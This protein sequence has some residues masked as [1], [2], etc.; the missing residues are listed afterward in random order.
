VTAAVRRGAGG[1]PV[2]CQTVD[3]STEAPPS[4]P[5]EVIVV[6]PY[7]PD[8]APIDRAGRLLAG[9]G[10]VVFPTETVYGLGA[11]AFDLAAVQAVF[12][13]KGRPA[14]DPL[15]VHVADLDGVRDV[16]AGWPPA[17]AALAEAFW[18][19]PLT[20]VLPKRPVVPDEITAG[21]PTV[22]V[23]VP[24]HPVTQ[25]VLR[26]AGVPVAAPSANRFGRVSPT[27]A[28]HVRSELH[29]AYDLLLDAG[30]T[31]LGVEST[32]VDL[33]GEVP[34]LL[35]P[36][37]VVLEDL[38][39]VIGEVRH[40]DR[41]V[42]AEID[43]AAAPGQ[44]LRHYAPTTPLVLVEG[45]GELVDTLRAT[46]ASQGFD[47]GVVELPAAPDAAARQLYAALRDADARGHGV[48]LA[49]VVD[50]AGLGRAVNDRLFRAAHGRVVA[51]ATPP[52]LQRIEHL[53][54]PA[55][56]HPG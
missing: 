1:V 32:V 21:R 17:A 45:A 55:D 10:L 8:P 53:V 22:A 23:R 36:G 30:P 18:P 51:D 6:D 20:L 28:E 35:R 25:A 7:R 14:T 3:V 5:S 15:I 13:G 4:R 2:G 11:H 41:I 38:R 12:A 16:V 39:Q 33:T 24:A 42:V 29:G 37:G 40:Q 26:A 50:P 49:P 56:H 47:A 46:L 27:T 52:T 34:E 54:S 48:L 31:P 9:G 19:G 43:D 44:F